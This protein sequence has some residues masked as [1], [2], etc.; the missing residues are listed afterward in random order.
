MGKRFGRNQKRKMRE[1]V[2]AVEYEAARWKRRHDEERARGARNQQIVEDTADVLGRY[3]I[4]LEPQ[5]REIQ[6]VDQIA[7][8]WRVPVMR[9][10]PMAV[11]ANAQEC[12]QPQEFVV[13]TLPVLRG[14]VLGDPLREQTHIRFTYAGKVVGYSIPPMGLCAMPQAWAVKKIAGEMSRVLV[15][16]LRG[17]TA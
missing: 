17:G 11:G 16:E 7:N 3:F 13:R 2:Q 1:L 10:V 5:L 12:P 9:D 15:D 4:T 8:G 14:S 6:H